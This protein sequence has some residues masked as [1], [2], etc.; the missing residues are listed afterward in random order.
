MA[1]RYLIYRTDYND[2]VIR[3]SSISGTTGVNEGELYT[4]FLIP[5][6]QPLYYW[7]VDVGYSLVIPNSEEWIGKWEN[8]ISPATPNDFAT[9][10]ELT[11]ATTQLQNDVNYL[12][13]KT[14]TKL[15]KSIFDTYSGTTVPNTYETISKFNA[16]T[17][18]TQAS[19]NSKLDKATFS[20]YSGTTVP[21]TYETIAKFNAYTGATQTKL[22]A[23]ANLSGATFTGAIYAPTA[24]QNTSTTQVATTAYVVGQAATTQPLMNGCVAIGTSLQYARQD[25]IYPRD[26]SKLSLSGGTMTGALRVNSTIVATGLISGATCV[27]SPIILASSYVCSSIITGSTK[28]CSPIV[29]ATSCVRSALVSGTT[30]CAT[31]CLRNAGTTR[32]V[33]AASTLSITGATTG[34]T[35]FLTTTPPVANINKPVLFWN[36]TSKQIEAKTLTGGSDT[37][38][39]T[40]STAGCTTT[41]TAVYCKY[42]GVTGTSMCAGRYN[43]RYNSEYTQTTNARRT[44]QQ[45]RVDNTAQG[46]T[47]TGYVAIAGQIIT[48][49]F[50]R[51]I[52]LSA[53]THCFDMV[54]CNGAGGGGPI[55]TMCYG[56]ISVTRLC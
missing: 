31:S 27:E 18:A 5:A 52:T 22:N 23:K 43:I 42:I 14:D 54:F 33:G 35:M 4:D 55:A 13:G 39:Y 44:V 2:T 12:S 26:T 24:I 11:G 41:S 20:T 28:I 45:F 16:Y 3:E 36:S 1:F 30:V 7:K 48:A 21:N 9:L 15:D 6:I 46:Q 25:H 37:Y 38:L 8:H 49:S 51:D 29:C 40:E 17:G 32:L 10:G 50:M 19:I 34:S 53:G 47:I 56:S